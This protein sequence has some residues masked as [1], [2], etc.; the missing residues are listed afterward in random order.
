MR[1]ITTFRLS[2]RKLSTFAINW[3][4]AINNSNV[5]EST[6]GPLYEALVSNKA[7]FSAAILRGKHSELTIELNRIG[8]ERNVT[9]SG[10]KGM[11][12]NLTKS[13]IQAEREAATLLFKVFTSSGSSLTRAICSE[14]TGVIN[15]LLGE[16]S[17]ASYNGAIT[18]INLG[19]WITKLTELQASYI[20]V[21]SQRDSHQRSIKETKCA[22]TLRIDLTEAINNYY[23]WVYGLT[24]SSNVEG[25]KTLEAELMYRYQKAIASISSK[26]DN[27][28]SSDTDSTTPSQE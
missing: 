6:Q 26:P 21:N 14:Q 15:S 27:Q 11:V 8:Q 20:S 22:T 5:P 23:D 2:N 28:S 17:N 9:V 13:P 7:M 10:M 19:Y 24:L 3:I 4:E 25:W 1:K 12:R 16:L 18:T